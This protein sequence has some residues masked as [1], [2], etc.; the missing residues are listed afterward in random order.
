[1]PAEMAITRLNQGGKNRS[2]PFPAHPTNDGEVV[3]TIR[4]PRYG[5]DRRPGVSAPHELLVCRQTER[6]AVQMFET[7]YEY[8]YPGLPSGLSYVRDVATVSCGHLSERA[9]SGTT[10]TG[11]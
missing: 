11:K 10:G 1:M 7:L 2:G 5:R 9:R 8:G 4:R 6:I 3:P